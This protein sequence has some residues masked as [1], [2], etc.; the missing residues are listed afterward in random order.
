MRPAAPTQVMRIARLLLP[1]LLAAGVLAWFVL[2]RK[3]A[4]KPVSAPPPAADRP[5]AAKGAE[6]PTPEPEATRSAAGDVAVGDVVATPAE[7]QPD[8]S[9]PLPGASIAPLFG[10]AEVFADTYREVSPEDRRKRRD[11]IEAA[12][13]EYPAD[14]TDPREFQ[15]YVALK[16]ESE[17][18]RTNPGN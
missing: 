2:D 5:L 15:K 10:G 1:L 11:E 9:G 13:A 6:A 8:P 12:L 4:Q 3:E 17:W 16:E 14:P 7:P 18:L